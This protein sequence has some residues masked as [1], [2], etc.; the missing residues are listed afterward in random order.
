[1]TPTGL[2]SLQKLLGKTQKR[3]RG[4]APEEA[5]SGLAA[6]WG[7]LPDVIKA[8]IPSLVKATGG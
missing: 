2:Q 5:R 6:E 8:I 7:K 4:D 3:K 1:V